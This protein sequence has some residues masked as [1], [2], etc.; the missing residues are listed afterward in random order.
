MGSIE[1][2]VFIIHY[3]AGYIAAGPSPGR[4]GGPGARDAGPRGE[5]DGV[6]YFFRRFGSGPLGRGEAAGFFGLLRAGKGGHQGPRSSAFSVP[7]W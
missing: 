6:R 1:G 2:H 3:S 4:V 7:L 5:R